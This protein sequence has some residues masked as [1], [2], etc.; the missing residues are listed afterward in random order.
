[1]TGCFARLG[2]DV[3]TGDAD[4]DVPK[5]FEGHHGRVVWLV[6]L[7]RVLSCEVAHGRRKGGRRRRRRGPVD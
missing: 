5:P 3:Q 4:M 6:E 1:M 7:G 2:N